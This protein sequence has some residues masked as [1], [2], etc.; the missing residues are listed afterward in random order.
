MGADGFSGG[1]SVGTLSALDEDGESGAA[2]VLG[3]FLVAGV[4]AAGVRGSFTVVTGSIG[5]VGGA[6]LALTGAFGGLGLV[7]VILV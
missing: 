3:V 6:N 4:S 2:V 7:L 5:W 1:D